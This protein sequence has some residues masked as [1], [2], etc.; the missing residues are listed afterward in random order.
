MN[1]RLEKST[2]AAAFASR[3]AEPAGIQQG[4]IIHLLF[5]GHSTWPWT[6][7]HRRGGTVY[8][9]SEG[10]RVETHTR[11]A[12]QGWVRL[13]RARVETRKKES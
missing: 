5:N 10:G 7:T 8:L 9:R 4:D 2:F 11:Q 13:G 1:M 6:V 3:D 12:I